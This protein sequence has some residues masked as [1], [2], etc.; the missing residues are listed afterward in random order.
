MSNDLDKYQKEI[1]E[2]LHNGE[3]V[4]MLGM[5]G[6][7]KSYLIRKLKDI[8]PNKN[9][10]ITSTTGVSAINIGGY[11][12]HSFFGIGLGTEKKEILYNK[13]RFY[14]KVKDRLI[15]KDLLIVVDEVSMLAADLLE[16]IDY[17]LRRLRYNNDLFGGVQFLFAGDF[18]QLE[19]IEKDNILDSS[20]IQNFKII[21]LKDNYRQLNDKK[22]LEILK[23]IR[24]NDLTKENLEILKNKEISYDD[25]DLYPDYPI[26]FP[27]IKQVQEF[28]NKK[29]NCINE[30]EITYS[31]S[32]QGSCK[33]SKT[34]LHDFLNKRNCLTLK[35]KKGVRVMLTWNL[36][37]KNKLVNGSC[38]YVKEMLV[39]NIIVKFDHLEN[40]IAINKQNFDILDENGKCLAKAKQ[41]PL[42]ISYA[43]TI[44]KSQGV[45][46]DKAI[47]D[48]G[49]CF[50]N[51]QVYVAI[52]RVKT[53]DGL[54]LLNFDENKIIVNDFIIDFYKRII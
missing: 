29:Y 40:A 54:K 49:N 18:L 13:M 3:N 21:E 47:I 14:K 23:N 4:L 53:L 28:N 42:M 48:V 15:K 16:K 11:T 31:A 17:I 50:C 20:F 24:Y 35:L 7:G 30:K 25:L 45:T 9:I 37:T 6:S 2:N 12:F 44:H 41:I 39:D 34:K 52:S 38:G 22:F 33:Y 36:D 10:Y 51:H 5:A 8:L 19:T 46:L 26:L 32:I 1:I 43:L 27:L